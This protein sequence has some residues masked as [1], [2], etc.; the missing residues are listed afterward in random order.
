MIIVSQR[1]KQTTGRSR[2]NDDGL[3]WYIRLIGRSPLLTPSEEIELGYRVRRMMNLL[4]SGVEIGSDPSHRLVIRTGERAKTRMIEANLRLVV[5]VAKKYVGFG[6]DL[7]DLIQEGT[8]GLQRAVEKFDPS[9]G[10]KFSTYAFWWIRQGMTRGIN[11]QSRMIRLPGHASDL[12]FKAR[13][14]GA[15]IAQRSGAGVSRFDIAKEIGIS[16]EEL[17]DLLQRSLQV[18]SLDAPLASESAHGCVMDTVMDLSDD[19]LDAVDSSLQLEELYRQLST[20]TAQEK[21]VIH[22]RYGLTAAPI[23][24]L[25]EIGHHLGVSRERIRQIE[26]RA[27]RKLQRASESTNLKAA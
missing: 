5:T 17:D 27:I 4:E 18:S 9:R 22:L 2:T 7:L 25:T 3:S 11:G 14:A 12:L 23:H 26:Q 1:E 13:R 21:T 15:Q 10:Y 20:L 16:V 24:T 6:I 19:P 8:I